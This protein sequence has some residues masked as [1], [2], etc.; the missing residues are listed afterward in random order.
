MSVALSF[1]AP[2]PGFEPLCD[3][4]LSPIEA[5]HGLYALSATRQA[6]VRLYVVDA[7]L[8]L[9]DYHP[10]ITAEQAAALGLAVPEDA[11]V[12]VVA[13]PAGRGTTVN[14]MAPVVVN[15]TTGTAAQVILEGQEWPIRS[16]LHPRSAAA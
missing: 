7:A 2:P 13:N 14:L 5:A 16:E 8:Y 12:L 10:V 9:P 6:D 11:L 15:S 4:T 3:F 1:I